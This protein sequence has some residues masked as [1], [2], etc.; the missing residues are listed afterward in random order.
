MR[1]S[2]LVLIILL[3]SA[4]APLEAV[5]QVLET[6]ESRPLAR[7]RVEL[8]GGVEF[9]TA[10]EGNETAVPLALEYG[11][12]E[13]FTLLLEPVFFTAIRPTSGARATGLG[14]LEVTA[15]YH[16]MSERGAAPSISLAGEIK[17]PTARN[18]LIGTGQ[19][20]FTPYL[21]ASKTT[22]RFFTSANLSYTFI[23]KPPGTSASN[24]FNY[25]IG[26]I[27]SASARHILY[28][29]VFGNTSALGGGETPEV[30]AV[31]ATTAELS[32]GETVGAVGYGYYVSPGVLGSIGVSY[33]NNKAI[34]FRPGLEWFF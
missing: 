13:R 19:T 8:G 27:F 20:D 7:G 33:D 11:L 24:L 29:E 30:P 18:A 2:H 26:T 5:A 34:L 31:N 4:V 17:I 3:S 15:F 16:L 22:G 1:V 14:D 12:T 21:I 25:A 23:G 6:E 32:G 9:Q 28:A 10:K